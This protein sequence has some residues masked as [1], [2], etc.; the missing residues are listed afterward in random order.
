MEI[1]IK[2]VELAEYSL[3]ITRSYFIFERQILHLKLNHLLREQLIEIRNMGFFA[4]SIQLKMVL[5][6]AFNVYYFLHWTPYTMF[7]FLLET[8]YFHTIVQFIREALK[9]QL[10]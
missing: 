7:D 3:L 9:K 6:L 8:K 10:G 4:R 2:N 5:Y 1:E